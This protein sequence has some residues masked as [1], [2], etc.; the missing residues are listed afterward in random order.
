MFKNYPDWTKSIHKD[1]HIFIIIALAVTFLLSSASAHLGWI[2]TI[3]TLWCVYFFRN[4]ERQTPTNA[5]LV[6]SP[7]DGVV[8]SITN[9][10][11][12]AELGLP[13]EEMKK[14]SIFL[15]VFDVHVNRVPCDG[16]IL[17]LHYHPGK[18]LNASLD[19][20]S[21]HNERQSILMET[22]SGKKIAFV[23]IAGLIA[24]RIV[25]DLEE[26]IDV[27]AGQRFG[28]IRF[29]SRVDVYLPLD[30]VINVNEGQMMIG[31]ETIIANLEEKKP[32]QLIFEVR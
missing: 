19:K 32:T 27:K 14:V 21:I 9:S 4:P 1:G 16:K 30:T 3:G 24:R 7:A 15:S 12:P 8:H 23:Q 29:G 25:C 28:I 22:A 2:C 5:G 18:F 31:G 26:G 13:D 11:A 17:T 6:I 20:A 10:K